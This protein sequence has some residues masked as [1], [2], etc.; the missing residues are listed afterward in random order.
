MLFKAYIQYKGSLHQI[1]S[2]SKCALNDGFGESWDRI[3]TR[4]IVYNNGGIASCSRGSQIHF[5]QAYKYAGET[6]WL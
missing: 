4:D 6:L 2:N 1:A 5:R 3:S